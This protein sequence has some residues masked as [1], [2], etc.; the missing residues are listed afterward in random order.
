MLSEMLVLD[1]KRYFLAASPVFTSV[2][3]PLLSRG[4]GL[5]EKVATRQKA[6]VAGQRSTTRF[7]GT[8][9]RTWGG[10]LAWPV[11]AGSLS[12]SVLGC[13]EGVVCDWLCQ[14]EGGPGFAPVDTLLESGPKGPWGA[15]LPS[16]RPTLGGT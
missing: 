7:A 9:H 16:P 13:D 6:N 4:A 5:V 12:C 15:S 1:Y 3:S 2:C 14:L 11:A 8:G 10:S